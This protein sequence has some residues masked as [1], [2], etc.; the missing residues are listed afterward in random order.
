[1]SGL[2]VAA[3]S[4]ARARERAAGLDAYALK[5]WPAIKWRLDLTRAAQ[6]VFAKS[7]QVMLVALCRRFVF[8]LVF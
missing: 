5:N 3:Q 6:L 2:E 1:M 4:E 8:F 7:C